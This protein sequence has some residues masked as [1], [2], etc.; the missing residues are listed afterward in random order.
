MPVLAAR[1]GRLQEMSSAAAQK[2]PRLRSPFARAVVPVVGG[3]AFF[4]A[5]A[6]VTWAIAAYVSR[7]GAEVTERLAPT[8]FAVGSA[9][10][11][12]EIVEQEGPIIF[13]GLATTTGEK[14]LVLD[15]RG[16]D[17]TRGWQIFSAFPAG[18]DYS[19]PVEQVIGTRQFV[20]CDGDTIDVSELAPPDPGVNP[21]VENQ[22]TLY[23]DL[24]GVTNG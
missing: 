15:H 22:R 20:D 9:Q 11:T 7:G 13:P 21:V 19:C 4:V 6:L 18:R 5:L 24:S 17:P 2:S 14:T 12:A 1:P 16:D 10:S 8:T 3:I 23:I